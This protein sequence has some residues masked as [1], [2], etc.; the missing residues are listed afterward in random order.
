MSKEGLHEKYHKNGKIDYRVNYKNG[1]LDGLWQIY[2]ENGQ[3]HETGNYKDGQQDGFWEYFEEDGS[4]LKTE[5]WN[6]MKLIEIVNYKNGNLDGLTE[7]YY[8]DSQLHYKKTYKGGKQN[9][10]EEWYFESGQLGF[11]KFYKDGKRDG[12]QESYFN[13]GL[14]QYKEN[15]KDGKVE[16]HQETYQYNGQ[17]ICEGNIVDGKLDG[18]YVEWYSNDQIKKEGNYKAG[19][20]D[21]KYVEWDDD[22]EIKLDKHYKNGK[23]FFVIDKNY[24]LNNFTLYLTT[25]PA[26]AGGS[27]LGYL[28]RYC[29]N[30]VPYM[31]EEEFPYLNNWDEVFGIASI[32]VYGLFDSRSNADWFT[33]HITGGQREWTMPL[34]EHSKTPS[35]GIRKTNKGNYAVYHE[36][37]HFY[38]GV[39][40]QWKEVHHVLGIEGDLDTHLYMYKLACIK[41]NKGLS[42]SGMLD[43]A[44]FLY[45]NQLKCNAEFPPNVSIDYNKFFI[46]VNKE[47]VMKFIVG[48]FVPANQGMDNK[49][50]SICDMIR[51]YTKLNKELLNDR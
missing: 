39:E 1:K 16:G 14:I 12:N 15:Y 49:L 19:K 8:D 11:K 35:G 24:I 51:T 37:H 47:E 23:E 5:T 45:N 26:G 22:G 43:R 46:D 25:V 32:G 13:N 31:K 2:Y 33:N 9:G 42:E 30:E 44:T 17:K 18:K 41:N 21:G 10:Y 50:D 38:Y 29:Q 27:F 40:K 36:G 7:Q 4:L 48:T 34:G 3:L 28:Q 6:N 20:L